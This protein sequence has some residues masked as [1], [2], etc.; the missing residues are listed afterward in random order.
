MKKNKYN[1]KEFKNLFLSFMVLNV[2]F[3]KMG[4]ELKDVYLSHKLLIPLLP[5]FPDGDDILDPFVF[6]DMI[7]AGN[8]SCLKGDA[9]KAFGF[10]KEFAINVAP[11]WNIKEPGLEFWQG[12][13]GNF[14][15]DQIIGASWGDEYASPVV[16]PVKIVALLGMKD[17]V[18]EQKK[19]WD[20]FFK[21]RE[22]R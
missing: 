22:E 1:L 20:K 12:L 8:I 7:I 4:W 9:S 19:L 6:R 5:V 18:K 10:D 11:G 15:E 16:I 3:K 2:L 14:S 13:I 21:T 17:I